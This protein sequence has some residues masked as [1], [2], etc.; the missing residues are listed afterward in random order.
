MQE[1]RWKGN[2]VLY[3]MAGRKRKIKGKSGDRKHKDIP[4]ALKAPTRR[5]RR[6]QQDGQGGSCC[7]GKNNAPWEDKAGRMKQLEAWNNHY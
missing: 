2:N 6:N 4:L 1:R 5:R 3:M 7:S